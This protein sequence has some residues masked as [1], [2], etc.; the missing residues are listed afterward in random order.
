MGTHKVPSQRLSLPRIYRER[1][2]CMGQ[3]FDGKISWAD[4]E[5]IGQIRTFLEKEG[6][7][8]ESVVFLFSD[9]GDEL[10][11]SDPPYAWGGHDAKLLECVMKVPLV[12][13]CPKRIASGTRVSQQ[14]R[15]VDVLPTVLE[16]AGLPV[17]AHLDGESLL[18]PAMQRPATPGDEHYAYIENAPKGWC[19]LRTERWKLIMTDKSPEQAAAPGPGGLLAALRKAV[20]AAAHSLA[21]DRERA[22]SW[23][24]GP[25]EAAYR[26]IRPVVRASRTLR[27]LLRSP[28]AAS[29][30]KRPKGVDRPLLANLRVHALY[31]LHLDPDETTDVSAE[32]PEVVQR[33]RRRLREMMATGPRTAREVSGTEREEVQRRLE[34]LGYR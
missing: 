28:K 13:Y 7:L 25:S 11:R 2:S 4:H 8:E 23:L 22:P 6:L 31:N 29:A 16:L 32:H 18:G 24:Y 15:L 30:Q 3:F 26:M 27:G 10:P 12:M 21:E 1:Y 19:G 33:L 5:C 14:V 17:P 9:H 34:A 20:R